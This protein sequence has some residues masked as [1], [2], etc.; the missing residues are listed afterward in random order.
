MNK[1]WENL[2]KPLF[3]GAL[4]LFLGSFLAF[5]SMI[6]D[7]KPKGPPIITRVFPVVDG[8]FTAYSNYVVKD[9][10]TGLEWYCRHDPQFK[11]INSAS[12]SEWAKNLS[13]DGGG[14]RMPSL[15]ELYGLYGAGSYNQGSKFGLEND[16]TGNRSPL[17]YTLESD[18]SCL[19]MW[20]W[21]GDTIVEIRGVF[22]GS[23]VSH[24]IR[25]AKDGEELL[26]FDF[27]GGGGEGTGPNAAADN[28]S[29]LVGMLSAKIVYA[30]VFAV[31]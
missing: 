9:S 1:L 13:V 26:Y 6:E 5:P 2:N 30:G 16:W 21:S 10:R 23:G 28:I 11:G 25:T 3:F 8:P 7:L 29:L 18:H 14:W 22:L 4:A 17:L 31:R 27:L 12:A 15:E 20:V 19:N 24:E